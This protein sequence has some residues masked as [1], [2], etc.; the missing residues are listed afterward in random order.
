[1]GACMGKKGTKRLSNSA[2]P[3]RQRERERLFFFRVLPPSHLSSSLY[4][5]TRFQTPPSSL[6]KPVSTLPTPPSPTYTTPT[7][8][9]QAPRRRSWIRLPTREA[10]ALTH[11]SRRPSPTESLALISLPTHALLD[12]PL[13]YFSRAIHGFVGGSSLQFHISRSYLIQRSYTAACR[14]HIHLIVLW[15]PSTGTIHCHPSQTARSYRL[16]PRPTVFLLITNPKQHLSS[17]VIFSIYSLAFFVLHCQ[18]N[19]DV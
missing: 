10:S 1:M 4:G 8:I 13:T 6:W 15:Q 19:T 11:P 9:L 14:I 17:V 5:P 18:P 7:T 3:K 12:H 16:P 2:W